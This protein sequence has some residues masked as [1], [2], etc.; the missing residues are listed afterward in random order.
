MGD[1][2][3]NDMERELD[4]TAA[5]LLDELS[6]ITDNSI[7]PGEIIVK[8][9]ALKMSISENAA[10]KRLNKLCDTGLLSKRMARHHGNSVCAYRRAD[11]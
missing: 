5:D 1:E 3:T 9:Y 10:L 4:V 6:S 11:D 8:D 2:K 7:L